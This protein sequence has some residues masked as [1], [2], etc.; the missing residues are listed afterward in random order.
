M[1]KT[2]L[3]AL[4][5]TLAVGAIAVTAAVT[6]TTNNKD[7]SPR[8]STAAAEDKNTTD[9][10]DIDIANAAA[11]AAPD[12]FESSIVR[13]ES[14][15]TVFET[16]I[17]TETSS[18][19]KASEEAV[20]DT[21]DTTTVSEAFGEGVT[22]S[23]ETTTQTVKPAQTIPPEPEDQTPVPQDQTEEPASPPLSKGGRQAFKQYPAGVTDADLY[24]EYSWDENYYYFPMS[25]AQIT[26]DDY[27]ILCNCVALEY[28]A[29]WVPEGEMALVAEVVLN[30]Y[31]NW[32][33]SSIRDVITAPNQFEG[34][35]SYANIDGFSSRVNSRVINA[36]NTY[37]S[38]PQYFDEG[39]TSFRG[40]GTWNYFW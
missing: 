15:T 1:K 7:F 39:Y 10:I 19:S 24:Y 5:C 23:A 3:T 40:D 26:V 32:G 16:E 8:I 22:E 2:K 27:Y 12:S 11:A 33:Y 38:F 4:V 9:P 13:K 20:T 25:G 31:N 37:L 30:R 17:T 18:D 14:E 21:T 6:R 36:V 28:G 34:S 35:G 29:D